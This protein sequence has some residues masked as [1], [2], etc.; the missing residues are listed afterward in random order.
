[1][2]LAAGI[3]Y[4]GFDSLKQCGS[5]TCGH[6]DPDTT[7]L[8]TRQRFI[9]RIKRS[10]KPVAFVVD[11]DTRCARHGTSNKN[12]AI[13][14]EFVSHED[15]FLALRQDARRASRYKAPIKKARNNGLSFPIDCYR[16]H[17]IYP[18]CVGHRLAWAIAQLVMNEKHCNA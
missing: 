16:S 2:P 13:N 17:I 7:W 9:V 3:D 8:L 14:N 15:S 12:V 6:I 1:M 5:D 11:T 18:P 4:I 10:H